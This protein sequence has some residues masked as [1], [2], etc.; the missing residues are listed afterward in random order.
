M[1]FRSRPCAHHCHGRPAR[2]CGRCGARTGPWYPA[3][4]ITSRAAR[5]T[6]QPRM[7]RP[8]ATASWTRFRAASRPAVTTPNTLSTS[9]DGLPVTPVH[10]MLVHRARPVQLSPQIEQHEGVPANPEGRV[11]R[12]AVRRVP[13]AGASTATIGGASVT[14]PSSANHVSICC[15]TPSSSTPRLALSSRAMYSNA[16]SLMR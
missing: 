4:A 3:A 9:A 13:G 2:G 7:A 5:S 15:C 14:R 11:G 10:A 16:A 12:R 8:A 1:R 6:S